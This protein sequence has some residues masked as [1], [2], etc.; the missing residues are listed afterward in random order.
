MRD[1]VYE[2]RS[3]QEV[4][5]RLNRRGTRSWLKKT[6]TARPWALNF[7]FTTQESKIARESPTNTKINSRRGDHTNREKVAHPGERR[8]T[9]KKP[10]N[11]P[12]KSWAFFAGGQ[13][14]GR[15]SWRRP[16]Q[17]GETEIFIWN[18]GLERKVRAGKGEK[19][20]ENSS[21]VWWRVYLAAE[22]REK[23]A[24]SVIRGRLEVFF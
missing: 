16:E 20:T 13:R 24:V 10:R 1:T 14:D 19:S 22:G 5:P 12:T 17:I 8:S 4:I 21:E 9:G 6:T 23:G 11:H 18:F 3:K 2:D 15:G 7:T